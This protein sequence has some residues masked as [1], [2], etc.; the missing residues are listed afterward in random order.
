MCNVQQESKYQYWQRIKTRRPILHRKY[1]S[2]S[3]VLL[4]FTYSLTLYLSPC[5]TFCNG[6]FN[7]FFSLYVGDGNSNGNHKEKNSNKHT[8]HTAHDCNHFNYTTI[9]KM[10]K[11][12]LNKICTSTKTIANANHK[13]KDFQPPKLE[14]GHIGVVKYD[15]SNWLN[16]TDSI[17]SCEQMCIRAVLG[18]VCFDYVGLSCCTAIMSTKQ[19]TVEVLV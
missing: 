19:Q 14:K 16:W 13:Q 7:S 5:R 8:K 12:Q 9:R 2:N 10:Q 18:V 3:N 1:G 11:K 6:H 17:W 4:S 15:W